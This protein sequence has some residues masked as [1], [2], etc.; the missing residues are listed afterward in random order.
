MGAAFRLL[1]QTIVLI[2]FTL[3]ILSLNEAHGGFQ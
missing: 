3:Q 1:A 2:E